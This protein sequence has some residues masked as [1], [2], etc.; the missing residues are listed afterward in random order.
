[1]IIGGNPTVEYWAKERLI[2][3]RVEITSGKIVLYALEGFVLE[4]LA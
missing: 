1:M 3:L 4:E 2:S